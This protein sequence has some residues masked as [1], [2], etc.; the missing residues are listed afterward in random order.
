MDKKI[1]TLAFPCRDGQILLGYKKRGFGAGLYNGFGGK[2]ESGETIES[3]ML[4]ELKEE[5]DL[6]AT[7]Y[8]KL[9]VLNFHYTD[10]EMEVHVFKVNE[11][12]GEPSESEEMT[13]VW[14]EPADIPLTKMWP[15]DEYWLPLFLADKPF[16]GKYWFGEE[17]DELGRLKITKQELTELKTC[18]FA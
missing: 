7:K 2:L 9:G 17:T 13:A 4:R 6:I 10:R 18:Y 8:T 12:L 15:D 14:Y 1:L 3:G 16:A 11:F 5:V